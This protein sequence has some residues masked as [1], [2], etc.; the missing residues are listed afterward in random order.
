[1]PETKWK[2]EAE[3][4][5]SCNCDYGC[6]CNFNALPSHGNCEAF[7]AW[8]IRK[9]TFGSTKLDGV[10]FAWGLW[11]PGAIHHGKGTGRVYVDSKATPE[12]RKAIEA[13]T[14]GKQGGGV[15]AVFPS[16]FAKTL[17]M[18]VAKID[19]RFKGY[20][21]SFRV[22]G[23]GEVVSDHIRNPVTGA[24][25]ESQII[26]PGGINFKKAEVTAIRRWSLRDDAAGWNMA[27]E[28]AAGFVALQKYT[29]KGPVA[30]AS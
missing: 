18:K 14:S 4:I 28:N 20:G 24:E 2:F 10:T 27:Y 5:Q 26:L 9:G 8:H 3:Y 11:W 1:M 22:E 13:I 7:N 17:P 15:F 16:T 6:P 23:I 19:F 30:R 25:F 21:S 12:Q 29:E